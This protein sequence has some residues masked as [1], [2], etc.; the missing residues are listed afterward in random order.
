MW[1]NIAADFVVSNANNSPHCEVY[2]LALHWNDVDVQ[3][4]YKK[5]GVNVWN[6]KVNLC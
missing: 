6:M 3:F 5:V 1:C 2:T 4:I